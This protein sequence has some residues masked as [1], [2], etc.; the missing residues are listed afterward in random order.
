MC[1][2]MYVCVRLSVYVYELCSIYGNEINRSND[3]EVQ[4]PSTKLTSVTAVM[5]IVTNS[6]V[7]LT[8]SFPL[9]HYK[10]LPRQVW[11]RYVHTC[12]FVSMVWLRR[13]GDITSWHV[14]RHV[15]SEMSLNDIRAYQCYCDVDLTCCL[16]SQKWETKSNVWLHRLQ[17]WQADTIPH[18]IPNDSGLYRGGLTDLRA[19][20]LC[21]V[22]KIRS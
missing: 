15:G 21:Y 6:V 17:H 2:C 20:F 8:M 13:A 12:N 10:I 5:S 3:S 19:E 22:H 18:N 16:W 9:R 7:A 14:S 1:V 11:M 4:R